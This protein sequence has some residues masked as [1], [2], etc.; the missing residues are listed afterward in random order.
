MTAWRATGLQLRGARYNNTYVQ[1][2]ASHAGGQFSAI[3]QMSFDSRS[4]DASSQQGAGDALVARH[5]A[6]IRMAKE[7]RRGRAST[8][9]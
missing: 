3:R 4:C 1:F 7:R 9:R 8:L 5:P 2:V 6:A